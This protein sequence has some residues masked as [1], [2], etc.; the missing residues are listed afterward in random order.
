MRASTIGLALAL[1][2][3]ACS[4]GNAPSTD[5][6]VVIFTVTDGDDPDQDGYLIEVDGLDSLPVGPTD[7]AE[8]RVS[9]GRHTFRLLGVAE[10]C[11][12]AP[13][14]SL[15]LD[16]APQTTVSIRF[17]MQCP[18]I[19]RP[20]GIARIIAAT[21]GDAVPAATRYKVWLEHFGAWDYGGSWLALGDLDPNDTLVVELA[22]SSESGLDPYWYLFHLSVPDACGFLE[23]RPA[24]PEVPGF[25]LAPGDTLDIEFAVTCSSDPW[26]YTRARAPGLESS[27][28]RFRPEK[29]PPAP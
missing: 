3:A 20:P 29:K 23:P 19:P 17:Q 22:A 25:T 16:V 10:R 27:L 1:A 13:G 26:G 4:D 14:N 18:S 15:Q 24:S 21:T 28:W 11:S 12:V 8:K 5:G 2:L 7:T 6:T 9:A